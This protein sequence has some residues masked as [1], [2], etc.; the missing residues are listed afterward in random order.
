[1]KRSR[2]TGAGAAADNNNTHNGLILF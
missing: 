2:F 1:L